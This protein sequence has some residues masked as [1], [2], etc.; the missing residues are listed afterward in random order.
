[1]LLLETVPLS[2][3]N[4]NTWWSAPVFPRRM[5]R[6]GGYFKGNLRIFCALVLISIIGFRLSNN[7]SISQRN[8]LNLVTFS[9]GNP[10]TELITPAR[11]ASCATT[12][13]DVPC[14]MNS[15][16]YTMPK[17]IPAE[18]CASCSRPLDGIKEAG[19]WKNPCRRYP[20][21]QVL[22]CSTTG[23]RSPTVSIDAPTSTTSYLPLMPHGNR[24]A[25][26]SCSDTEP[27]AA[28]GAN[29]LSG[30]DSASSWFSEATES[31]IGEH[32]VSM[33]NIEE[34]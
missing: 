8:Y 20:H 18:P 25:R 32:G 23:Y 31:R 5:S 4:R 22:R 1:M 3:S 14:D 29:S 24:G 19:H 9:S 21:F 2:R 15:Y 30:P 17:K 7:P 16:R 28:W 12:D 11:A 10:P 33:N 6:D 34:A 13:F 27:G 26:W